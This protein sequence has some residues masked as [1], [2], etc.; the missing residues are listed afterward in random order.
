[1]VLADKGIG[2]AQWLEQGLDTRS[3]R[4]VV[5]PREI[6]HYVE[7]DDMTIRLTGYSPPD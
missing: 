5:N 3:S 2:Y 7:Q 6:S 1:M 4:E